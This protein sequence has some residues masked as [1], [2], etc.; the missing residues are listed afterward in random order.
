MHLAEKILLAQPLTFGG[1]LPD[2]TDGKDQKC[3]DSCDTATPIRC[4]INNWL[5]QQTWRAI[6]LVGGADDAKVQLAQTYFKA[7]K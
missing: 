6:V 4:A 3:G 2:H 1:R 7:S 5:Q